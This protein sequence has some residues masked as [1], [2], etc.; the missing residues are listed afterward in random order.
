[1]KLLLIEDD[2]GIGDFIR[3]GFQQ[4][5]HQLDWIKR[6]DDGLAHARNKKYQCLILDIMLPGL[7]GISVLKELR[8]SNCNTPVIILSARQS[9]DD[10]IVG[11]KAGGDDYLVKPFAFSELLVRV[12]VLVRRM[13]RGTPQNNILNCADLTLD[14]LTRRVSRMDK[15]IEM[16]PRE[17]ALLELLLRNQGNVLTKTLILEKIWHW[18]F[19]P[20]T[21]VV[22]V[23]VS[24]L[25]SRID[26]E[27]EEKLIHTVR[28]AGY[29]LKVKKR[30]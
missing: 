25:R 28:G 23:L 14:L 8:H 7:D 29:V 12:E 27:Y 30:N 5:G 24:R 11:L 18:N 3:K 17:F 20:Q 2:E 16:Q 1:M 13:D 4:E 19:D 22:D 6:G 10:R 26:K 21:N 15:E 9:V